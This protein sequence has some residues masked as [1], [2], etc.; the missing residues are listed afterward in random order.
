MGMIGVYSHGQ[1]PLHLWIFKQCGD[2][3]MNVHFRQYLNVA[4]N[5]CY[6]EKSDQRERIWITPQFQAHN[7]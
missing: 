4:C 2:K 6:L 1:H 5:C 3:Q 7:N